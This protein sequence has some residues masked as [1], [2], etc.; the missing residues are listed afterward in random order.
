MSSRFIS[1]GVQNNGDGY[2]SECTLWIVDASPAREG[3]KPFSAF[4]DATLLPGQTKYARVF[5]FHE[6]GELSRP[7]HNAIILCEP[8]KGGFFRRD[9]SIP[10]LGRD[11]AT[12]ISL[13]AIARESA[14]TEAHCRVWIDQDRKLRV[15]AV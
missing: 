5:R 4:S 8:W 6:A 15:E 2:L 9:N 3:F 7:P 14:S 12:I 11:E 13:K 1:I 10:P